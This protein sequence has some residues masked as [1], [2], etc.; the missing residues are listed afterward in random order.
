MDV[1]SPRKRRYSAM[2]P[3]GKSVLATTSRLS[4][5]LLRGW[6]DG[7]GRI[8]TLV[9]VQSDQI[10][11]DD[12]KVSPDGR[13]VA[14]I[15]RSSGDVWVRS[16]V[17]AGLLQVSLKSTEGNPVVWGPDSKRLY[18]ANTE[19]LNMIELQTTP[20][21]SVLKRRLIGH[22][23]SV[24]DY[25]LSPDGRQFIVVSPVGATSDVVVVVNWIE[26]ARRALGATASR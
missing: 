12:P 10:R 9:S 1:K 17:G 4:A 21:L 16:L 20:T 18:H 14:F 25:D 19:G 23:P 3:D 6:L 8:D 13:W 2:A 26:E 7:S 22:F 24:S 11:P 5:S 15:E